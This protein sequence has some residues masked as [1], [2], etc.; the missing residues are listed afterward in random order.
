LV[1]AESEGQTIVYYTEKFMG[2]AQESKSSL[3]FEHIPIVKIEAF[4]A[5]LLRTTEMVGILEHMETC[6]ECERRLRDCI[7][8]ERDYQPVTIGMDFEDWFRHEHLDYEQLVAFVDEKMDAEEREFFNLHLDFCERCSGD[9]RSLLDFRSRLDAELSYRRERAQEQYINDKKPIW[10]RRPAIAWR[11]LYIGATLL[12]LGFAVYLAIFRA[13]RRS[14]GPSTQTVSASPTPFATPVPDQTPAV[15]RTAPSPQQMTSTHAI[16]HRPPSAPGTERLSQVAVLKDA[17]REIRIG[18]T[19]VVGGME[20]LPSDLTR[21]INESLIAENIVKPA[22]LDEVES[23]Q[24]TLRAGESRKSRFK[25]L[26][27]GRMVI[28][29][30]R[31]TFKW[32]PLDGATGYEVIVGEIS[33]QKAAHIDQLPASVTQWTP[34]APLGRGKVYSWV[35]KATI[36]GEKINS[37]IPPDPEMKFKVLD[38]SSV[39]KLEAINKTRSHLALGVFYAR[40]GMIDEAEL[41][42]EALRRENPDSPVIAA[43]LRAVRSWR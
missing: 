7:R 3:M 13:G 18:K 1:D 37:P 4:R 21:A 39:K 26:S 25:L 36:N 15:V 29:E 12:I 42:F 24:G 5:N 2:A 38:E 16:N 33:G 34:P 31:P 28:F 8:A 20:S 22:S 17:G 41:E 27:P 30:R 6:E 11:P 43:L 10:S 23:E 35:V 19:G 40:A 32:E 9:V 14:D